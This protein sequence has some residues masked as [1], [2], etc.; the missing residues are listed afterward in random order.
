MRL[1][2]PQTFGA[3]TF[4][5]D[6]RSSNR[7]FFKKHSSQEIHNSPVR[8]EMTLVGSMADI[9]VS[10]GSLVSIFVSLGSLTRI[11]VSLDI[12][13]GIFVSLDILAGIFVSLDS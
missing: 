3:L 7:L 2:Q 4:K 13:A 12:L 6:S 8:F 1:E 5:N 10:L 9:V 11:F